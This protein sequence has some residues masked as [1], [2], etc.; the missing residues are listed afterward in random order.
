MSG[1]IRNDLTGQRFG[2]FV[3]LG[4]SPTTIPGKDTR[5]ECQCDCGNKKTVTRSALKYGY[6]K[7]CGC[8]RRELRQNSRHKN[9]HLY[10][11]WQ[12]MKQRCQ[13]PNNSYYHR[14]GARGISVCKEWSEEYEPF[15]RWAIEHGYK[16]GLQI[17][18]IENDGDYSPENCRWATPKENS[19]NTS[20]NRRINLNGE[21]RTRAEWAEITNIPVTTIRSRQER[22]LTAEEILQRA[23]T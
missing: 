6:T 11:V 16:Q 21:S 22:G 1:R 19:N 12:D 9:K 17:D 10:Q 2:R 18:R 3:V 20:R 4:F 7:S 8:M 5:W 13:N 15:Y 23:A 14:Y